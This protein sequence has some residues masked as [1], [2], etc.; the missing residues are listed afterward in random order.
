[1]RNHSA[2]KMNLLQE[3]SFHKKYEIQSIFS[4]NS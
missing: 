1:M 4:Q 2:F 3:L